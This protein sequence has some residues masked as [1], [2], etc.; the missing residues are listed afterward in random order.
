M[1]SLGF[2]T[3][4]LIIHLYDPNMLA[5]IRRQA[6]AVTAASS[7]ASS[8]SAAAAASSAAAEV[9][10]ARSALPRFARLCFRNEAPHAF[11]QHLQSSL[12]AGV[13]RHAPPAAALVGGKSLAA[14]LAKEFT[15]AHAGISGIE[16]VAKKRERAIDR[17][18]EQAF[19]DLDALMANAKTVVD[20]STRL[21]Q[22]SARGEASSER[23]E[24][25]SIL[26]D[27]GIANPVTREMAGSDYHMQLARQMADFLPDI[28]EKQG[29]TRVRAHSAAARV[30]EAQ[31]TRPFCERHAQHGRVVSHAFGL[32]ASFAFLVSLCV[33]A[34]IQAACFF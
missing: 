5:F 33:C 20:L 15:T 18:L 25:Q 6:A 7:S 29:R 22:Q 26:S 12:S 30:A 28:M 21:A 16:R 8:L 9:A 10:P 24:L 2:G 23:S 13:W 3:P 31:Q 19:Q 11:L 1:L 4:K 27:M 14:P 17:T 32:L 34:P